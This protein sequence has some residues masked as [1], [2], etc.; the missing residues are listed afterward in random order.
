MNPRQGRSS[1]ATAALL[2]GTREV[3]H[4]ADN[5]PGDYAAQGTALAWQSVLGVPPQIDSD[6]YFEGGDSLRALRLAAEIRTNTGK[7]VGVSDVLSATTF[8]ELVSLV[9]AT[10]AEARP[11]IAL[12]DW[13]ARVPISLQQ[14]TRLRAE[15][16]KAEAARGNLI[17]FD[18][19]INGVGKAAIQDAVSAIWARHSALRT[20]FRGYQ[21]ARLLD[22]EDT[23]FF[24]LAGDWDRPFDLREGPL[25][26][27]RLQ[28]M[29]PWEHRLEVGVEH[30]VFDGESRDILVRELGLALATPIRVRQATLPLQYADYAAAQALWL[31]ET[32]RALLCSEW[33]DTL[34]VTGPL[35]TMPLRAIGR[36]FGVR[37]QVV[38][39]VE[40]ITASC[41][42]EAARLKGSTALGLV[43]GTLG[44]AFYDLGWRQGLQV[45]TARAGRSLAGSEDIIGYFATVTMLSLDLGRG[46]RNLIRQQ[47]IDRVKRGVGIEEIPYLLI[48]RELFPR[49]Y[50]AHARGDVVDYVN[51]QVLD[52][53]PLVYEDAGIRVSVASDGSTRTQW[54]AYGGVRLTVRLR[55]RVELV[56]EFARGGYEA[57]TILSVLRAWSS[58]MCEAVRSAGH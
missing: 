21:T 51:L 17:R 22:R 34:P 53:E 39:D 26:Q 42:H 25:F 16:L 54:R 36:T 32:K 20:V 45:L 29:G 9:R 40:G 56:A 10:I 49:E 31:P 12:H 52:G 50:R 23:S 48:L 8:G 27:A 58:T 14:Q 4:A 37:Q 38:V 3:P 15:K 28:S 19:V 2:S 30:I 7:D 33:R 18:L 44:E 43:F 55:E 13:G 35:P 1:G 24:S 6:F 41:V 5:W 11:P 46:G 47:A 57:S